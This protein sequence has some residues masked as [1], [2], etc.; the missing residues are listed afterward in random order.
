MPLDDFRWLKINFLTL[1]EMTTHFITFRET[2]VITQ[3]LFHGH[4][5]HIFE[6]TSGKVQKHDFFE[7]GTRIAKMK[8]QKSFFEIAIRRLPVTQ[9]QF[10][11]LDRGFYTFS[12][13]QRDPSHHL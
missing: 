2:Q 10:S 7:N 5:T 13:A 9:N 12:F 3:T 4:T 8:P 1:R 11:N 6:Y